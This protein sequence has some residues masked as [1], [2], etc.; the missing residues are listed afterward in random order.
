MFE[1]FLRS[2]ATDFRRRYEGTYGFFRRKN[3]PAMLCRLTGVSDRVAF[4]DRHGQEFSL[5][6]D[7]EDEIGFEFLPPK[8]RWYNTELG[9]VWVY[10]KVDRQYTR[11]VSDRTVSISSLSRGTFKPMSVG[12]VTLERIFQPKITDEKAFENFMADKLK[13]VA[14]SEAFALSDDNG[15]FLN[16]LRI[17]SYTK[18]ETALK[19]VLDDKKLF[20]TELNDALRGKTKEVTFE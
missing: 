4:Q 14:L 17:G 15:I 18:E 5:N 9:A 10:R 12:F 16:N 6:A 3:E 1:K 19:F 7:A 20:R 8:S 13:T 2:D 11:G